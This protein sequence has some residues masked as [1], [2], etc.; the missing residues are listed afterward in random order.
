MH[1]PLRRAAGLLPHALTA[2]VGCDRPPTPAVSSATRGAAHLG[3]PAGCPAAPGWVAV[4]A[5]SPGRRDAA[6]GAAYLDTAGVERARGAVAAWLE[7]RRV[8][9]GD[10]PACLVER[11][12]IRCRAGGAA[13]YGA[14]SALMV[15]LGEGEP[16]P[17]LPPPGRAAGATWRAAGRDTMLAAVLRGACGRLGLAGRGRPDA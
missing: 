9:D 5:P 14:V 2:V 16:P 12:A 6:R 11:L 13:E 17:R 7:F 15:P 8:P 4:R 10:P 3:A 1:R